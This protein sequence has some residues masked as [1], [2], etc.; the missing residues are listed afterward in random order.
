MASRRNTAAAAQGAKAEC[1]VLSRLSH[2]NEDYEV[3]DIVELT[4]AEF[5]ALGPQV[6]E[7]LQPVPAAKA[8]A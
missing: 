6:V 1:R 4:E 2:D 8:D 7:L 5:H 3:D